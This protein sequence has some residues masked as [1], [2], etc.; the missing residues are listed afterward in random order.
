ML[1]F[2]ETY[3]SLK[4]GI[5]DSLKKGILLISQVRQENV[6]VLDVPENPCRRQL[7]TGG[8]L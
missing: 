4:K 2:N 5:F 6:R 8:M 3:I 7:M 1:F